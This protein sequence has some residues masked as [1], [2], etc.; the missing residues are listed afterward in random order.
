VNAAHDQ[1]TWRVRMTV[2]QLPVSARLHIIR[3]RVRHV[4]AGVLGASPKEE[5]GIRQVKRR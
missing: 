2:N 4:S 3:A 5:P 1:A